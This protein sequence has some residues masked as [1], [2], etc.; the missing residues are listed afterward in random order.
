MDPI[1]R[2][3][4]EGLARIAAQPGFENYQPSFSVIDQPQALAA[5]EPM[6]IETINTQPNTLLPGP[7][8]DIKQ[9]LKDAAINKATDFAAKKLGIETTT[10]KL[11][12]G[13]LTNPFGLAT[14]PA[15]L[16]GTGFLAFGSSL[17]NRKKRLEEKR[18]ENAIKR[19]IA[20]SMQEENKANLTGGYQY[21]TQGGGGGAGRD[22]MEGSGTSKDMGSS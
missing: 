8:V 9:I 7:Q 1:E 5:P 2:Q 20:R 16:T 17:F 22:F 19:D 21:G 18:Q 3:I 13:A 11:L 15:A 14:I 6:G 10:A 12:G 4:Q